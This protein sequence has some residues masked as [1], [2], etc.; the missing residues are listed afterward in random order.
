MSNDQKLIDGLKDLA[1][2]YWE[3]NSYPL[4][5]SNLPPLLATDISDYKEILGGRTLKKFV[6]ET[7]GSETYKLAEHPKQRAKVAILPPNVNYQ[8]PD[9]ASNTEPQEDKGRSSER[10]L[11][12]FLRVLRNLPEADI[13]E[14]SIPV[15]VLVKLMK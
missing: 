14:V 10:A 7:S 6:Q 12:E 5:L 2:S 15:S 8:F 13:A 3:S 9:Q 11:I 1:K 4:L